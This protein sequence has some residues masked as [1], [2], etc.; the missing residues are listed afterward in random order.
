M[1]HLKCCTKAHF[2]IPTPEQRLVVHRIGKSDEH[3]REGP[4]GQHEAAFVILA[5]G[6]DLDQLKCDSRRH[7]WKTCPAFDRRQDRVLGSD[8]VSKQEIEQTRTGLLSIPPFSRGFPRD[9]RPSL[10]RQLVAPRR[11]ALPAERL[12]ALV[13]ARIAGVF[14]R[15]ARQNLGD[16]VV[17]VSAGRFWPC[18]PFGMS[19]P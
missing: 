12:G 5:T 11:A 19:A 13:L 18:G 7:A 2:E 14:L 17:T 9:L 16:A 3:R 6:K 15:L 10:W 8:S 1:P 4:I